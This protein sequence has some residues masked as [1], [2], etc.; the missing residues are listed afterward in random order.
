MT[1]Y[2]YE[3]YTGKYF[4]KH[5]ASPDKDSLA[6]M[7]NIFR[8][9]KVKNEMYFLQ[10]G[11]KS[12]EMAMVTK[13]L[14]RSYYIDEKG[15]DVTKYFYPEG[16]MLFSYA[17]YLTNRNSMYSIQA[18]EDSEILTARIADF[19]EAIKGNY[20]LLLFYK[21]ILDE[22]LVNKEEHACSFKLLNSTERYKQFLIRYPGLEKR[23]RQY[24]LASYLGITPVSL[25]RIKNKLNL[26]K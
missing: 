19:E 13:G 14:F 15:K 16:S 10:E 9:K 3:D 26:N 8:H 20:N 22:V 11:E 1:K 24:Q 5:G 18:M 17:A 2:E 7:H 21:K 4:D 25:S 12:T 6:L 23:V